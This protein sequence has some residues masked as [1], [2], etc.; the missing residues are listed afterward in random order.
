MAKKSSGIISDVFWNGVVLLISVF[1]LRLT[2]IDIA[3]DI[4]LRDH[5]VKVLGELEMAKRYSTNIFTTGYSF[6]IKYL[7][8][9]HTQNFNVTRNL[10]YTYVHNEK[11]T[12]DQPIEIVYLPENHTISKP[13]EMLGRWFYWGASPFV[14]GF[15]G[16]LFALMF[17]LMLR[18][19]Y[20]K[21][22]S[23]RTPYKP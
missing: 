1:M 4:Q 22:Q 2:Y 20:K 6:S 7:D 15:I 11:F 10:F 5:G 13:T 18:S 3:E 14:N 16:V 23:S 9:N 12:Q 19:K 17:C 8:L 21:L